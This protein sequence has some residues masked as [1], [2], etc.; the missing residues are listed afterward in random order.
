M[1]IRITCLHCGR[2]VIT[3]HPS[4]E[5]LRKQMERRWS[6]PA[7]GTHGDTYLYKKIKMEVINDNRTVD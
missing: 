4:I 6:C 1:Q 3:E 7:G 5:L 2:S